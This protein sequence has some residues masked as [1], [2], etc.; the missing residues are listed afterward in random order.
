MA[1]PNLYWI[2]GIIKTNMP[3]EIC[4]VENFTHVKP[5]R[6]TQSKRMHA[7]GFGVSS[8]TDVLGCRIV[9]SGEDTPRLNFATLL[10]IQSDYIEAYNMDG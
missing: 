6:L 3:I 2:D 1:I 7:S 9:K 10:H 5:S 8:F 4:I